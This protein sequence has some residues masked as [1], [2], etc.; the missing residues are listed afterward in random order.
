MNS[1]EKAVILNVVA[2]FTLCASVSI[3]GETGAIPAKIKFNR[4]IRPILSSKCFACHGADAKQVKGG[5][6][7]DLRENATSSDAIVPGKPA[8]SELVRRIRSDDADERMPPEDTHKSLSDVE[9]DLL[10][11]WIAERS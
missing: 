1:V 6:R 2:I 11:S 10:A 7:L 8:A 4:D 3:A 5:L 9:K